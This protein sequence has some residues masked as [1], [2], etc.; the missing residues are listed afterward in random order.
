MTKLL[1]LKKRKQK[2]YDE[3][4]KS[5]FAECEEFPKLK[6]GEEIIMEIS[7]MTIYLIDPISNFSL[8]NSI[9]VQKI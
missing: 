3:I 5:S 7:D 2:L 8:E 4:L 6:N 9:K 1:R